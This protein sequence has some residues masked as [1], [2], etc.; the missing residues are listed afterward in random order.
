M[1][2]APSTT[3]LDCSTT[4]DAF[5]RATRNEAVRTA[6]RTLVSGIPGAVDIAARAMHASVLYQASI[7]GIR[8]ES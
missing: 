2:Q 3:P 5:V 7:Y 6:T 1:E 8:V 4:Q